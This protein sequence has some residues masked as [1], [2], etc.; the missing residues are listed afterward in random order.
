[1]VSPQVGY[2]LPAL[3][4]DV[5]AYGFAHVL[6]SFCCYPVGNCDGSQAPGLCAE[7]PAGLLVLVTLIQQEL[8]DLD[9]TR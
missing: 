6:S 4:S 8:W 9:N 7:N 5:I 1:M 2:H 3:K